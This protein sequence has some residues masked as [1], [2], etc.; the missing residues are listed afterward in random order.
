MIC[1]TAISWVHRQ[2]AFL[3]CS[4]GCLGTY[5]LDTGRGARPRHAG[6]RRKACCSAATPTCKFPGPIMAPR[7]AGLSSATQQC[8]KADPP[9]SSALQ[10][11][12]LSHLRQ[13]A[14]TR[15]PIGAPSRPA[16]GEPAGLPGRPLAAVSWAV[17]RYLK[18]PCVPDSFFSSAI[19]PVQS[20]I[21]LRV[22]LRNGPAQPTDSTG[23]GARL[24]PLARRLSRPAVRG[25]ARPCRNSRGW[26]VHAG[27]EQCHV[28]NLALSKPRHRG[29]PVLRHL[30]QQLGDIRAASHRVRIPRRR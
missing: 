25:Q 12:E 27:K 1:A 9:R 13:N 15:L 20:T 5:H 24:G 16:P 8:K 22:E 14:H 6:S 28:D 4:R 7:P 18:R 23:R 29:L 26:L 2:R 17:G 21:L 3:A 10:W 11:R 19:L 30:H